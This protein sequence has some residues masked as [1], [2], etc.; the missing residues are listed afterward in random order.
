[1][2]TIRKYRSQGDASFSKVSGEDPVALWRGPEASERKKSPHHQYS[3]H[4]TSWG[5]A[6]AKT[7]PF[8]KAGQGGFLVSP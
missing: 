7:P 2:G 8:C 6:R 3:S 4:E 1:M 5:R